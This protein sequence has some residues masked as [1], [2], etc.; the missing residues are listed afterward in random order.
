VLYFLSGL[1]SSDE[2]ARTKSFAQVYAN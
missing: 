1:T 2:N